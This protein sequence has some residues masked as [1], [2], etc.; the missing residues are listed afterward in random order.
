MLTLSQNQPNCNGRVK[1]VSHRD[2]TR[3]RPAGC[4]EIK[5][6]LA[7]RTWLV[8]QY[9]KVYALAFESSWNKT[10]DKWHIHC[11][12]QKKVIA[13]W[14]IIPRHHSF[15][16]VDDMPTTFRYGRLKPFKNVQIV[17]KLTRSAPFRFFQDKLVRATE[18]RGR[19]R[20]LRP[21]FSC[22]T[23]EWI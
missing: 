17:L 16:S 21:V 12:A 23:I 7:G 4:N 6:R 10:K 9:H 15:G 11:E 3:G 8:V 18:Q 14:L 22:F 20:I 19:T 13:Y 2:A 1:N 5:L